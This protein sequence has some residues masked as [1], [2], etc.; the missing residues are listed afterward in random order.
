MSDYDCAAEHLCFIGAI[1][2]SATGVHLDPTNSITNPRF[3]YD[4]ATFLKREFEI[5]GDAVVSIHLKDL[6]LNPAKF[7]VTMEE[8]VI[9]RGNIDYI[10]LLCLTDKLP[11]DT[12]GM[13]EHLA[14][15]TLY[16]VA[17]DSIRGLAD[18]TGVTFR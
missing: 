14:T 9:E 6:C 1:N 7:T 18:K 13:L 16:N 17:A 8:V 12:P 2:R 5:F 10:N 4:N 11:P 15:E 3:L